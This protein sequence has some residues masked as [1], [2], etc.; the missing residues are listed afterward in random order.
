[1]AGAGGVGGSHM[2]AAQAFNPYA[3]AYVESA[4]LSPQMY[5]SPQ[6][7]QFN[8]QFGGIDPAYAAYVASVYGQAGFPFMRF[9]PQG[10]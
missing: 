1:M 8:Q 5:G 3:G 7:Q 9:G 4:Q 2:L 10:W 6:L